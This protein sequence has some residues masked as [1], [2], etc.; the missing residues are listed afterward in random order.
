MAARPYWKGQIRLALVSIP[1]E[2][3][4]ATRSGATIAFNQ[5]HEPSGQRIKYEKV[6]PGIGW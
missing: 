4:P 1:V 3:Y 6:V 5:I 2:I